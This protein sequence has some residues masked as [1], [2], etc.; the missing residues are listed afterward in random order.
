MRRKLIALLLIC[1]I[2]VGFFPSIGVSRVEAENKVYKAS[3]F[4][5]LNNYINLPDYCGSCVLNMDKDV[6]LSFITVNGDLRITGSGHLSVGAIYVTGKLTFDSKTDVEVYDTGGY[7]IKDGEKIG[8]FYSQVVYADKD[9]DICMDAKLNIPI[10]SGDSEDCFW[11]INSK[12]TI[13]TAGDIIIASAKA[14]ISANNIDIIG[15]EINMSSKYY[16]LDA[17]NDIHIYSGTVNVSC[18]ITSSMDAK[19][20]F[21]SGGSIKVFGWIGSSQKLQIT[22]GTLLADARLEVLTGEEVIISGGHIELTCDNTSI[23]AHK[24]IITGGELNAFSDLN[25]DTPQNIIAWDSISIGDNMNINTPKN[26]KISDGKYYKYHIIANPDGSVP[27]VICIEEKQKQKPKDNNNKSAK[28][29][30]E[31]VN[32]KWYDA[33][34]KQTYK[35][36]MS[37][38]SNESGWWIEDTSGWYP[39]DQWQKIDGTWYYFKPDGYM[40]ANEYYKGY[41]FNSNGS[42][43]DRYFLSWKQDSTGWWV[44]DKSGWW[45]SSSWLKIDGYWYYFDASGYMVTNQYIDGWW[46]GSD[47]VCR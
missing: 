43:D 16:S 20:I 42:W 39:V 38:K 31:W 47:G 23:N 27:H 24:F 8:A 34:G 15:G 10:F 28:Y 37:W 36:T 5:S 3:E 13:T 32:G 33:N 7:T 29:A 26:G 45:P 4:T 2:T 6:T 18:G 9:I 21:I 1:C 41:W 44:E 22:G 12:G 11:A 25:S 14:G 19:N 17:N 46:I 40:A 35:E 30:N